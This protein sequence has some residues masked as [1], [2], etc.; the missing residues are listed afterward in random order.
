M[1]AGGA[2]AGATI[3]GSIIKAQGERQEAKAAKKIA[4]QNAAALRVQA[5]QETEAGAEE[6]KQIKAEGEREKSRLRV[7]AANAGIDIVGTPL[8]QIEEFAS[9]FERERLFAGQAARQRRFGLEFEAAQETFRGKQI[10]L[11]S[12][13]RTA[14]TLLTGASSAASSF[15]TKPKPTSRTTRGSEGDFTPKIGRASCRE[16]V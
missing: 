5:E 9:E 15:N 7:L 10:R 13:F 1:G 2:A 12:R 3:A 6:Q 16:R 4:D 11:A 14:T 8:L